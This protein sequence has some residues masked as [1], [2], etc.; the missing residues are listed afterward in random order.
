MTDLAR[1]NA[2]LRAALLD[3]T[4]GPGRHVCI[5]CHGGESDESSCE[6]VFTGRLVD[7]HF[8]GWTGVAFDGDG[9]MWTHI[10]LCPECVRGPAEPVTKQGE[11]F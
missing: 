10:G 11:L 6:A 9:E 5:A 4:R 3:V 2:F 7:A 8:A 1:E